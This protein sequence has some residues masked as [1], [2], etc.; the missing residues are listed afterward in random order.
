MSARDALLLKTDAGWSLLP[1]G[2]AEP[3][4]IDDP[5]VDLAAAGVKRVAIALDSAS[6]LFHRLGSKPS[7]STLA[8]ELED[9]LP[10]DAEEIAC[11][12]QDSGD[13]TAACIATDAAPLR[14]LL[15]ELAVAG[16]EVV[17]IVPLAAALA[18]AASPTGNV[19]VHRGGWC[20]V[21]HRTSEGR[22]SDWRY[23]PVE[24]LG[25]ALAVQPIDGDVTVVG[26]PV[27][28][29]DFPAPSLDADAALHAVRSR[30]L[31]KRTK[32]RFDLLRDPSLGGSA[33]AA[34]RGPLL[35]FTLAAAILTAVW[36]GSLWLQTQRLAEQEA[37]AREDI[38]AAYARALPEAGRTRSPLK[39][40]RTERA[41]LAGSR[42]QDTGVPEVPSALTVL[43]ATLS[44]LPDDVRSQAS[45]LRIEDGSLRIDML[46]RDRLGVGQI[47]A[48]LKTGGFE[49]AATP[50]QPRDDGSISLTLQAEWQPKPDDAADETA[51]DAAEDAP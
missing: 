43:H 4:A 33:D 11:D 51:D 27:P 12:L 42:S 48:A 40:L 41:K 45:E 37:V 28:T 44:Q 14:L 9:A 21:L 25:D 31:K 13:G 8:F 22:L 35:A 3:H 50:T 5:A 30:L 26:D 10:L 46:L 32:H 7:R 2:E 38:R 19:I 47:A 6:V 29:G 24:Q 17:A 20:D 34:L 39:R 49:V 1:A 18:D 23:V 15:D 36:C 16:I